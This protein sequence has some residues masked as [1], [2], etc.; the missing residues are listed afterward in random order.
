M[1]ET[2]QQERCSRDAVLRVYWPGKPTQALCDDCGRLAFSLANAM[3]VELPAVPID[4]ARLY[5]AVHAM[6]IEIAENCLRLC[7]HS[8]RSR[9]GVWD[10]CDDCGSVRAD[11]PAGDGLWHEPS[12]RRLLLRELAAL[13][14]YPKPD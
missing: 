8:A 13:G 12:W 3:G 11:A 10:W 14:K 9:L 2:C 5:E 6:T 4:R 1:R 7:I